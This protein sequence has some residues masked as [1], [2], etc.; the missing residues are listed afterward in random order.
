MTPKDLADTIAGLIADQIRDA[1]LHDDEP[2]LPE[3]RNAQTT[4]NDNGVPTVVVT[5][6]DTP[7]IHVTV[8]T[9]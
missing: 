2:G 5:F 3:V 7:P 6:E 4:W 9:A 8:T 1:L